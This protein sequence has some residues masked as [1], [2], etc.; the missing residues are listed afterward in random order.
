MKVQGP[1]IP[2]QLLDKKPG[3]S[4]CFFLLPFPPSFKEER[5]EEGRSYMGRAQSQGCGPLGERNKSNDNKLILLALTMQGLLGV[6]P[7]TTRCV[8][9]TA[10]I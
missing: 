1:H 6:S 5:N 4:Y 8:H 9:T 10:L 3:V 7:I 2:S